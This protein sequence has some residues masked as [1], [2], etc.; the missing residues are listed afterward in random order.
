MAKKARYQDYEDGNVHMIQHEKP[1]T[2]RAGL[3]LY[4]RRHNL[5]TSSYINWKTMPEPTVVFALGAGVL[6]ELPDKPKRGRPANG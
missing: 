6:P 3:Y 2:F 4:A 1:E 5:N